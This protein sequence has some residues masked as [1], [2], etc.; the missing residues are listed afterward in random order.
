VTPDHG[1]SDVPSTQQDT[2]YV[3]C[4]ECDGKGLMQGDGGGWDDGGT[5]HDPGCE[6]C[7]GTGAGLMHRGKS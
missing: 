1:Q 2:Q 3:T 4:P 5:F 6:F 7:Q